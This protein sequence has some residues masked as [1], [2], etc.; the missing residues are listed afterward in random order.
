MDVGKRYMDGWISVWPD[1]GRERRIEWGAGG[2]W[3]VRWSGMYGDEWIDKYIEGHQLIDRW[4]NGW[5]IWG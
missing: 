4:M 2:G 3:M 1:G 5:S